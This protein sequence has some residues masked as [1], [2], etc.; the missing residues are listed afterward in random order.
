MLGLVL[1]S[2]EGVADHYPFK[3]EKRA[4]WSSESCLQLLSSKLVIM[5][6]RSRADNTTASSHDSNTV[7][8]G[9]GAS[10]NLNLNLNLL[11][12]ASAL[13]LSDAPVLQALNALL[14]YLQEHVYHL[15]DPSQRIV[16][17]AVKAISFD[18]YLQLDAISLYSLHVFHEDFHPNLLQLGA[19]S[20]GRGKNKEGYSLFSLFDRAKS[21]PGRAKLRDWM[22]KPLRCRERILRRQAGVALVVRAE[23]MD[24]ISY[25]ARLQ[26]HVF[27]VP[28]LLLRFKKVA[29]TVTEWDKLHKTLHHGLL[30]FDAA[31]QFTRQ[32]RPQPDKDYL[33]AQL[34]DFNP[35]PLR[36][37]KSVLEEVVDFGDSVSRGQVYIREGFD[38]N[39]DNLR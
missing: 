4:S 10:N 14:L 32:E 11:R 7:T 26:P 37:L 12:H 25:I 38:A 16:V 23:N 24:F 35:D 34:G 39:L 36:Q 9:A 20:G 17:S 13:D 29:A 28:S 31:V 5:S 6:E 3:V 33:L 1:S 15:D 2:K 18:Q 21:L 22:T 8:A 30:L 27:G 19:H